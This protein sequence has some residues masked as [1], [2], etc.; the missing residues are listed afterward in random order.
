MNETLNHPG[1][2][3]KLLYTHG[4]RAAEKDGEVVTCC[5][6]CSTFTEIADDQFLAALAW[7][8][9]ALRDADDLRTRVK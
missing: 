8:I 5:A 6:L 4:K 3:P 7:G 2:L 1:R 9:A